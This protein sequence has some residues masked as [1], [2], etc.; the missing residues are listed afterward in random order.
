MSTILRKVKAGYQSRAG[1]V[2]VNH[3]LF[4]DDLKL[5]GKNEAHIDSLVKIVHLF[6]EDIGMKFGIKKCGVLVMKREKVTECE[7]IRLLEGELI[8]ALE[9]VGY[10]YLGIP[11]FDRIMEEETQSKFV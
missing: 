5:F 6:T 4:M 11:E 3:L 7:G 2:T 9:K 1:Q 8:K 10:K